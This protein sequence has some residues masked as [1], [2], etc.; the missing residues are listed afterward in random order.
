MHVL[1]VELGGQRRDDLDEP[2]RDQRER[3]PEAAQGA[4]EGPGAGREAHGGADVVQH[5]GGQPGEAGDPF[6]Q[7]RGEVELAAHGPLGD[8]RDLGGPPGL[9]GEQLDHLVLDER[10]VDVHHDEA[11]AAAGQA[12]GGDRDVH[13][14]RGRLGGELA[15]Q[16][17]HV[18]AGD[19][20]LDRGHRVAGEPADAVD[21]GAPLGEPARRSPRPPRGAAGAP[22]SVTCR[23]PSRRGALSPVPAA[24]VTCSP[25][26]APVPCAAATRRAGVGAGRDQDGQGEP[27]PDDDLLDVEHL[28]AGPGERLE[29]R[30]RDAGPV[31]TGER[32]EH[33]RDV[34][35]RRHER[36]GYAPSR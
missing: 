11:P 35:A 7:A 10:R 18:V 26:A 19:V 34:G 5:R 1:D 22:I 4:A 2:A 24:Q 17:E 6:V 29:H 20:E 3:E 21:V 27:A 36:R 15:A 28:D 25:S 33:G 12:G 30:R 13:P 14:V 32:H 23:R 8:G 16:D 9:G 31:G